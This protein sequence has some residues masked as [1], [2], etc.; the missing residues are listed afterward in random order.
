MTEIFDL[1]FKHPSRWIIYGPS[2]SGKTT[3]VG[4]LMNKSEELFGLKFEDKIFCCDY[5]PDNQ[6]E[7]FSKVDNLKDELIQKLSRKKPSVIIL[8][9]VMNLAINDELVSDFF[10]KHSHHLNSTIIFITQNL[11]PKSKF[12]RNI[13]LNTSYIVLMKNPAEILQ[14]QSLSNRIAGKGERNKLIEAYNDATDQPFSYILVDLNQ[15]T[16]KK[17]R[18]RSDIFNKDYNQTVYF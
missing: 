16:P 5:E 18:F 8:D 9:D 2:Q 14:V 3:F 1:T 15:E 4:N 10:T 6:F 7:D 13:Y 12:M 11:F 17:L